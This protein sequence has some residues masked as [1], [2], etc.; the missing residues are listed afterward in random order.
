M[1]SLHMPRWHFLKI[2][3]LLVIKAAYLTEAE[4]LFLNWGGP[5]FLLNAR[6]MPAVDS[7]VHTPAVHMLVR[8]VASHC[9]LDGHQSTD[10]RPPL[11]ILL[12]S[13][14]WSA[15]IPMI[16]PFCY[17]KY[18]AI[19]SLKGL[20]FSRKACW[21][22]WLTMVPAWCQA[23]QNCQPPREICLFLSF[24]ML[25]SN[26][27]LCLFLSFWVLIWNGSLCMHKVLMALLCQMNW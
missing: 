21:C 25:I 8:V 2:K 15:L 7:C 3:L 26:G 17:F 16:P 20:V 9:P 11:C 6:K 27:S 13:P 23:L 19:C 18:V 4:K 10:L 12:Y 14:S 24:W 5:F 22:Q 1:R